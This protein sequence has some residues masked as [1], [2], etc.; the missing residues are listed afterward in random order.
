MN[1]SCEGCKGD[2]CT[3]FT[4]EFYK[5]QLTILQFRDHMEWIGRHH[6]VYVEKQDNTKRWAFVRFNYPCDYLGADGRCTDYANRPAT[7]RLYKCDKL[8]RA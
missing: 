3:S 2:C 6:E 5:P 1:P 7:C 4:E 8:R